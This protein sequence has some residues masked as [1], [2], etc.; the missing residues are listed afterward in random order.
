MIIIVLTT[1]LMKKILTAF[2]FVFV[3]A[4]VSV[5]GTDS[6][7]GRAHLG[8]AG[9]Q[10]QKEKAT[11]RIVEDGWHSVGK[12]VWYEGL[13]TIFD[14]IDNDLSWEIDVE[15]S[16]VVAGYYRFIPYCAGSPVAKAVGAPD[17]EYFYLDASNPDKVY[18][19]EFIAY[20]DFEFNYYFSQKV[21]ENLWDAEMYGQLIDGTVY[22]PPKSFGYFEPETAMFW[23]VN[24]DGDF[25]IVLPG[26]EARDN[27]TPKHTATFTD[28]FLAPFYGRD[29]RQI[30]VTVEERYLRPGYYR[31][32]GAFTDFGSNEYFIIDATNPEFV[33]VPYQELGIDHPERGEIV[34]YSHCENF[35]SPF[36]CVD[37]VE[38]SETYP[39]YVAKLVDGVA[40]FPPDA[41]V[42]HF[43]EYNPL[44]YWTN[45]DMARQSSIYLG[46]P[47]GVKEVG[48]TDETAQPEYYTLQ[49][50]RVERP[51]KG[52]YIVRRGTKT[53][54]VI[55]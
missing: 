50:I 4:A 6:P 3:G 45:D 7:V 27:W 51:G 53:E 5:A 14:E 32:K 37:W 54:K 33:T 8:S 29:A 10:A 1:N 28:G 43:P 2:T 18:S 20:R 9:V 15:E 55:F 26:G 23:D 44:S 40:I 36:K 17:N 39:Q 41:I 11:Q 47:S 24:F 52:L 48:M 35:I 46:E 12:G 19:E 25:K 30:K 38:Y 42:L 31:L 34:A 49:G 13:L 16:D 22:F 21:P